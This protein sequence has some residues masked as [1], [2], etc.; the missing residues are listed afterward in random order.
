MSF[1][2]VETVGRRT[3][4][5]WGGAIMAGVDFAIGGLGFAPAT[6]TAGAVLIT[7]CSI[8]VFI[9]SLSLAPIGWTSIVE[10]SSPRLRAKTAAVAT[11]I[12]SLSNIVFVSQPRLLLISMSGLMSQSYTVPY[13]LSD[14][15]AG[16]GAKIGFFFGGMAAAF[17]IPCYFLYPEVSSTSPLSLLTPL[18]QRTKL[19]RA[20]RV[21]RE[22]C[23]PQA[24]RKDSNGSSRS[25]G[26]PCRNFPITASTV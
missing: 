7:L 15:Y 2:T 6:S 22:R 1:Y 5:L 24:F 12:Q 25:C 9:Y 16:W 21:I 4:V 11:I 19:R 13:M 3:S 17:W 23:G 26:H 18:D 20:R 14:Q 10:V 8:W